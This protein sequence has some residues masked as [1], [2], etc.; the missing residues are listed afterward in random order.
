MIMFPM[1]IMHTKNLINFIHLI[2]RVKIINNSKKKLKIK[3]KLRVWNKLSVLWETISV[4]LNLS[5]FLCFKWHVD[6]KLY[7]Q[8]SRRY[9]TV[10]HG[11]IQHKVQRTHMSH[12]N[13]AN[14]TSLI[15]KSGLVS[16]IPYQKCIDKQTEI[17]VMDNH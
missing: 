1:F 4:S 12:T 5:A 16:E 13:I 7:V 17:L 8:Q 3:L 14:C 2:P 15:F 11:Y 6:R 9:C 10:T